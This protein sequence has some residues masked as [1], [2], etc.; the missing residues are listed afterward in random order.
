MSKIYYDTILY[1]GKNFN[2][3]NII[4]YTIN[5][6]DKFRN[7]EK[8]EYQFQIF[9]SNSFTY[10]SIDFNL[11]YKYKTLQNNNVFILIADAY[12]INDPEK[13]R[14]YIITITSTNEDYSYH[15][16]NNNF[17]IR[18]YD[19]EYSDF[20]NNIDF[21]IT[22]NE[23]YYTYSYHYDIEYKEIYI[24]NSLSKQLNEFIIYEQEFN[25]LSSPY[26]GFYKGST[27]EIEVNDRRF[28]I[29]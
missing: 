13:D 11:L 18:I 15:N 5:S 22:N 6:L 29:N 4:L 19:F 17:K 25:N 8:L 9:K 1:K 14:K 3:L 7:K 21:N 27:Y 16:E 28:I 12:Q 24:N 20:L 26:L 23:L 2:E 10:N